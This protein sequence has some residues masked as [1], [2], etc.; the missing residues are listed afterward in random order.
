M[1][2]DLTGWYSQLAFFPANGVW[3]RQRVVYIRS[4]SMGG[5]VHICRVYHQSFIT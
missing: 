2:V 5:M 4:I 3:R 1:S